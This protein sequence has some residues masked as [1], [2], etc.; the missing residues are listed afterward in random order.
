MNQRKYS[1]YT[2]NGIVLVSDK[3]GVILSLD[4]GK[5]GY[6]PYAELK[7]CGVDSQAFCKG[8]SY[9][10]FE[11]SKKKYDGMQQLCLH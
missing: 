2:V 1:Y 3:S 8:K 6:L 11:I 9:A 7:L 4:H 5:I 10:V